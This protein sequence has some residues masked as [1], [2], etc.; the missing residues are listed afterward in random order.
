MILLKFKNLSLTLLAALL[1]TGVLTG[2]ADQNE[3]DTEENETE[4][5]GETET[6]ETNE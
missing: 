6:E 2:C 3:V 4:T 5:P 1:F